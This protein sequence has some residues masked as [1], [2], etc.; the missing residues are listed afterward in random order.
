MNAIVY[1]CKQL[2]VIMWFKQISFFSPF[3]RAKTLGK[4]KLISQFEWNDQYQNHLTK[5]MHLN[6]L[7]NWFKHSM[8][9]VSIHQMGY[10]NSFVELTLSARA[11]SK[12]CFWNR[13]LICVCFS[14][15]M[16]NVKSIKCV[17]IFPVI[18]S[19]YW[20]NI[21][22]IAHKCLFTR[23]STTTKCTTMV[24]NSIVK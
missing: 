24:K 9:L 16:L 19:D 12:A 14:T 2:T 15:F 3:N 11:R 22:K 8:L 20:L 1:N 5:R 18:V 6:E 10:I 21:K 17:L 7:V 23:A 13:L 4:I